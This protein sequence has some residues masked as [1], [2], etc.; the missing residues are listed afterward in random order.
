MTKINGIWGKDIDIDWRKKEIIIK[1][2]GWTVKTKFPVF[3]D[4]DIKDD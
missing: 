2:N 4:C 3:H 1:E